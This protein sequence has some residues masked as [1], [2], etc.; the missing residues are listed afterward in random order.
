MRDHVLSAAITLEA[1]IIKCLLLCRNW[2]GLGVEVEDGIGA[3]V[4]L[5]VII[6]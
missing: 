5:S 2:K 1:E 6:H 4:P 3:A